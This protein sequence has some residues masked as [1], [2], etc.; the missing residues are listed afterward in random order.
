MSLYIIGRHFM[1]GC[2]TAVDS[3]L[4]HRP[5]PFA[6][7]MALSS[8][9]DAALSLSRLGIAESTVSVVQD[10]SLIPAG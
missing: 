4:C 5:T 1:Q 8:Q 10:M 9:M 6:T 3:H 7:A 2:D